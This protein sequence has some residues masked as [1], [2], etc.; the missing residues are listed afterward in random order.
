METSLILSNQRPNKALHRKNQPPL[1]YGCFSGELGRWPLHM[2]NWFLRRANKK[3]LSQMFSEFV[4]P[5]L[6]N[7][8]A[9]S[10]PPKLNELSD[11]TVEFVFVLVQGTNPN[12][13]GHNLGVI[14]RIAMQNGWMVQDLLCNLAVLVRGTLPTQEPLAADR[15]AL[16]DKLLQSLTPNIKIVHGR[17]HAFFGNMGST[18]RIT[19]GVLL[20]SFLEILAELSSLSY[21]RSLEHRG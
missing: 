21:G 13:T 19:Y 16:V 9:A 2:F 5:E 12:E 7:A 15:Y 6:L 8:V 18:A 11:G 1:R 17:E 10:G 4:S 20:P 3:Q 14:A